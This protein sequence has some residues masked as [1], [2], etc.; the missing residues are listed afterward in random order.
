MSAVD[1]TCRRVCGIVAS[2]PPNARSKLVRVDSIAVL[3]ASLRM[4]SPW[5]RSKLTSTPNRRVSSRVTRP[6]NVGLRER[7]SA[8]DVSMPS[9]GT[10]CGKRTLNRDANCAL[11]S[12]NSLAPSPNIHDAFARLDVAC[13]VVNGLPPGKVAASPPDGTGPKAPPTCPSTVHFG[14]SLGPGLLTC[15]D[16]WDGHRKAASVRSEEHTSELQSLRQ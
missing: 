13:S 14:G 10:I 6:P 4:T 5:L 11:T 2:S 9:S 7:P 16:A 1:A 3:A 8:A 15:A 12:L